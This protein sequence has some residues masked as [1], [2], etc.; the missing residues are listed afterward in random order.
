MSQPELNFVPRPDP[1]RCAKACTLVISQEGSGEETQSCFL[2]VVTDVIQQLAEFVRGR[3]LAQETDH[4][5]TRTSNEL[6]VAMIF[7]H[8][9]S[10]KHSPSETADSRTFSISSADCSSNLHESERHR[11]F[12]GNSRRSNGV[13]DVC[14]DRRKTV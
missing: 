5:S 12:I 8:S 4:F 7:D 9:D 3:N 10:R 2:T 11:D 1:D 13:S 6:I 14:I